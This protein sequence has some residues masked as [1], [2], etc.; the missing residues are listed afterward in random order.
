MTDHYRVLHIGTS[1]LFPAA[2]WKEV[3]VSYRLKQTEAVCEILRA[4]GVNDI[5][6]MRVGD[7]QLPRLLPEQMVSEERRRRIQAR[8][9]TQQQ[10]LPL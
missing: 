10:I 2:I 8:Y 1:R 9:A 7:I 3:D 4:I 5:N 6:E